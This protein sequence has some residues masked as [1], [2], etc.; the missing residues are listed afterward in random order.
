MKL[1]NEVKQSNHTVYTLQLNPFEK[2]MSRE[3][4]VEVFKDLMPGVYVGFDY[5][6]NFVDDRMELTIRTGIRA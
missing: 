2:N 6:V 4:L 3:G 1:L 5:T